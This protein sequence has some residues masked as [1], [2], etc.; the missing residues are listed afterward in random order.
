MKKDWENYFNTDRNRNWIYIYSLHIWLLLRIWQCDIHKSTQLNFNNFYLTGLP[1]WNLS[2]R[3]SNSFFPSLRQL[4]WEHVK[5]KLMPNKII[6]CKA[7]LCEQKNVLKLYIYTNKYLMFIKCMLMD[8]YQA[9]S[10][11]CVVQLN[12]RIFITQKHSTTY[13]NDVPIVV[14]H[15]FER[16]IGNRFFEFE[17]PSMRFHASL[18]VSALRISTCLA[19]LQLISPAFCQVHSTYSY[20]YSRHYLINTRKIRRFIESICETA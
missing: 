16:V 15:E 4:R 13:G 17:I 14:Y 6:L 11:S 19:E 7:S 3:K 20:T 2:T 1:S 8:K 18:N 9:M 10:L 5:L 12:W